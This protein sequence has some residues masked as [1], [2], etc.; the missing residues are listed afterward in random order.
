MACIDCERR[1]APNMLGK[2]GQAAEH[3]D[4]FGGWLSRGTE[5]LFASCVLVMREGRDNNRFPRLS[6]GV[7]IGP[8]TRG[9]R[10]R[11][12]PYAPKA[13]PRSSGGRLPR[14]ASTDTQRAVH[15]VSG[16]RRRP[17]CVIRRVSTTVRWPLGLVAAAVSA[18]RLWFPIEH[19]QGSA[20]PADCRIGGCRPRR[21]RGV[22][23]PA[24]RRCGTCSSTSAFIERGSGARCTGPCRASRAGPRSSGEPPADD[25]P[26][27]PLDV[28]RS[29]DASTTAVPPFR[30]R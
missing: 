10:D 3:V 24:G 26:G 30:S 6:H 8:S 22:D 16:S 20:Q 27:R 13:H 9:L 18:R 14:L 25:V 1:S 11:N 29:R 23:A 21:V 28:R 7:P 15:G 5:S 2:R 12:A 17:N 4:A 19:A